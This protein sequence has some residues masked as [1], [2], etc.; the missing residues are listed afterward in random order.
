MI[1][2]MEINILIDDDFKLCLDKTWLRCVTRETLRAQELGPDV[3]VGLVITGPERLCQLNRE[4]LGIN[5]PTDVLSFPMLSQPGAGEELGSPFVTPLDGV[6]HL[7]EVIISYPQA[8]TQAAE[9]QHPAKREVAILIIHGVLHLL[10]YDHAEAEAARQMSAL[11]S[12]ILSRIEE[13]C[14]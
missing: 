5:E 12:E 1:A 6:L 10:G 13:K 4:Y 9:R 11:E 14:L 7:G 8:V 2:P 3:E